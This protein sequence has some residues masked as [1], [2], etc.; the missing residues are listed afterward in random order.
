MYICHPDYAIH[1]LSRTGHTSWYLDEVEFT[2]GP[3]LDHNIEVTTLTAS[4]TTGSGITITASDIVGI[5][6]DTGFQSTDVGR[7]IHLGT[8]K[9]LAKIITVSSTLIVVADVI[10]TL[11]TTSANPK[12][13]SI[14]RVAVL[15]IFAESLALNWA[16]D[17]PA[18]GFNPNS[19]PL[20]KVSS[21]LAY[22]GKGG[23]LFSFCSITSSSS[24]LS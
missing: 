13:L 9:G 24:N 4:A 15:P 12:L 14:Y 7:L 11:S 5:N 21:S 23:R 20:A 17:S 22:Q 3:L 2:A 8:G 10:E 6:G 18:Y 19:L 1:K 16:K